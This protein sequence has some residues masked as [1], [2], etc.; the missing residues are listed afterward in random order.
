MTLCGSISADPDEIFHT[1]PRGPL[2][3]PCGTKP[4]PCRCAQ[5][6]PRAALC[7]S[8]GTRGNA[9]LRS[10]I[11]ITARSA[12]PATRRGGVNSSLVA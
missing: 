5:G 4:R 12:E 2:R 11:S 9:H 7:H 6:A 3:G 1:E 10:R 8:V